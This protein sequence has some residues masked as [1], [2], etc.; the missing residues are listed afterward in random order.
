[1]KVAVSACL[2]GRACKYNGR[3]NFDERLVA[4]LAGCEVVEVCPEV[5]GGLPIPRPCAELRAGRVMNRLGEDVTAAFQAGVQVCLEQARGCDVAVL[6]PRSPS[7]GVHEVYDGT[8]T[9]RLVA[10]RGLFAQALAEQGIPVLEP[11]EVSPCSP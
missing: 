7:C 11:E 10:G 2:L 9:G 5:A 4:A 1:M 8:F 6:Q 3:D